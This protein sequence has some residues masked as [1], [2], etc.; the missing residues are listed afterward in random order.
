M[1][2]SNVAAH[3]ADDEPPSLADDDDD[4]GVIH[5]EGE[6]MATDVPISSDRISECHS[7]DEDKME[8]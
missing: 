6:K 5:G 1:L 2:L 7:S 8:E 3:Q 4:E